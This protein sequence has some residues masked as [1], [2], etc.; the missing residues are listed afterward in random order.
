MDSDLLAIRK[1]LIAAGLPPKDQGFIRRYLGTP[2]E[3]LGVKTAL[4][5]KIARSNVK[6][7]TASQRSLTNILDDLYAGQSF[8]ERALAGH[9]LAF[10]SAVRSQVSYPQ[11]ARWIQQLQ[12]WA[13]IDTTCQS[14]FSAQ[15]V[16]ENWTRWEAWIKQLAHSS[17]ISQR[18]ASLVLQIK[19]L[20]ES[21]DPKLSALALHTVELL[22]PEKDILITK[23][24]SWILRGMIKKHVV[25]LNEYMQKEIQSLP[26][27][28]AREVTRKLKTGKK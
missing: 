15:E 14:S 9:M 17:A 27:I 24:I 22:K 21:D 12:G 26:K 8:E 3:V 2:R 25:M 20:R 5:K 11:L 10:S 19:S 4:L 23:A 6:V 16:L 13:E 1:Q 7:V 28:A 18:R